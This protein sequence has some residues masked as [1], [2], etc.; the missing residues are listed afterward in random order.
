GPAFADRGGGDGT[1]GGEVSADVR[2]NFAEWGPARLVGAVNAA[3]VRREMAEKHPMLSMFA[4]AVV[5]PSSA[6]HVEPDME[7]VEI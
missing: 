2:A 4:T 3:E 1:E 7:V 6:E 5:M